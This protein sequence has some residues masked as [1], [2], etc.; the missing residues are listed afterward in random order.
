M[1]KEYI[2]TTRKQI[3]AALQSSDISSRIDKMDR[4][5]T[6]KFILMDDAK[7]AAKDD[8]YKTAKTF[9]ECRVYVNATS[10]IY[11]HQF[12]AAL[13]IHVDGK[14]YQASGAMTSGCGYDK[15]SAAIDSAARSIGLDS[16]MVNYFSGTGEHKQVLG[17]LADVLAGRKAWFAV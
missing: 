16:D 8:R 12:M 7:K 1:K 3:I 4:H 2:K 9:V 10:G 11:G 5:A 6:Y 17:E 15:I 13:W 14:Y